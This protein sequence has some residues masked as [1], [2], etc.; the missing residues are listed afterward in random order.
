[1]LQR[2]YQW[3]FSAPGEFLTSGYQ[4]ASDN[5]DVGSIFTDMCSL[6]AIDFCFCHNCSPWV[7][8]ENPKK[9]FY[10][11]F[12]KELGSDDETSF[13]S[14]TGLNAWGRISFIVVTKCSPASLP[15]MI[16]VSSLKNS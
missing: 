3:Q 14:A 16:G 12:Y 10:D 6:L 9:F 5:D 11:L 1:M 13:L 4:I 15:I 7:D 2:I 8:E